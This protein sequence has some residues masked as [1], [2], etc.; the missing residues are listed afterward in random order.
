MRIPWIMVA[1][2]HTNAVFKENK[3]PGKQGYLIQMQ[4]VTD[5]GLR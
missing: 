3:E 2:T 5:S 4:L 1:L